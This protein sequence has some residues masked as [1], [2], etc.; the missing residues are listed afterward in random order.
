MRGATNENKIVDIN[1]K[2]MFFLSFFLNHE[3][4][5]PYEAN[6]NNKQTTTH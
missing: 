1:D 5:C 2:E 3:T 4:I 6:K